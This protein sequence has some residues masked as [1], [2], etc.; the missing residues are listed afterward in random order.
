MGRKKISHYANCRDTVTTIEK[1]LD[2]NHSMTHILNFIVTGDKIGYFHS[3]WKIL[4]FTPS[5]NFTKKDFTLR[6]IYLRN[7]FKWYTFQCER[8]YI[9]NENV[10]IK[11]GVLPKRFK[12]LPKRGKSTTQKGKIHYPKEQFTT[13]KKFRLHTV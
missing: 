1:R 8:W 11:F 6:E 2:L 12:S 3:K 10:N 4:N 13:Q 7:P 9:F 5:S